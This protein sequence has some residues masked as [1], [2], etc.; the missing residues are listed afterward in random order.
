MDNENPFGKSGKPDDSNP[1]GQ[2]PAVPS[3]SGLLRQL[4]DVPLGVAFP[5]GSRY[6]RR[7][8][9]AMG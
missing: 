4:A 3:G 9:P 5:T 8:K 7:L 2:S 6:R 1:F